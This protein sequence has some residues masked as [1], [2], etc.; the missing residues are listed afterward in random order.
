MSSRTRSTISKRRFLDRSWDR[1]LP[2]NSFIDGSN[3]SG[4]LDQSSHFGERSGFLSFVSE[5]TATGIHNGTGVKTASFDL[6]EE[7]HSTVLQRKSCCV[8]YIVMK[9]A[10][11]K[12]LRYAGQRRLGRKMD[13]FYEAK[14]MSKYFHLFRAASQISRRER[15]RLCRLFGTLIPLLLRKLRRTF[16]GLRRNISRHVLLAARKW[17]ST[18]ARQS[19]RS[20]AAFAAQKRA[21]KE[22]SLKS[23]LFSGQR[24]LTLAY[25]GLLMH[26]LSMGRTSRNRRPKGRTRKRAAGPTEAQGPGADVRIPGHARPV[27]EIAGQTCRCHGKGPGDISLA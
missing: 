4:C 2:N 24:M 21:S 19:L 7:K 12:L 5:E 11:V 8:G 27:P 18:R 10:F 9:M 22:L 16:L 23:A 26:C 25:N 17:A 3:F 15:Q 14:C 6:G 13:K 1:N 20:L